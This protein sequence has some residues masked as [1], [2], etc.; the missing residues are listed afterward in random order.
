MGKNCKC[1]RPYPDDA[2]DAC[3]DDMIQCIV[4]EDWFHLTHLKLHEDD[5]EKTESDFAELICDGCMGGNARSLVCYYEKLRAFAPGELPTV[6]ETE[7]QK[8]DVKLVYS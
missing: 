4:C 7:S 6:D 1:H 3:S 5:K 8:S 2:P